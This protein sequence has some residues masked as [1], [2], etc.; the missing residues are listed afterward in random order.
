[1][2]ERGIFGVPRVPEGMLGRK[3]LVGRVGQSP[4]TVIRAP[5]GGGK[6][7]LM[8]QWAAQKSASGVWVTV[9]PDIG[10][11]VSFWNAVVDAAHVVD[12]D[13][14]THLADVP[15]R[16]ALRGD[17]LRAF[18]AAP[19]PFVLVVDDAHELIDRATFE[20]ILAV[21]HACP[22]V[23]AVVGTRARDELES[24]RHALTLDIEVIGPDEL[25]LRAADVAAIAGEHGSR[26]GTTTELLEASGGNPLLLR[27]ILAGSLAGIGGQ[28]S[29][30]AVVLDY[31][32]G[33]FATDG[34]GF[35]AFAAATA[36]PD[37][38]DVQLAA[39]LSGL[40]TDRAESQ[41]TSLETDGLVM[42]RDSADGVR[43]RYHPLIREVLRGEMRRS[44]PDGFR[45]TS[46]RAS[47]SAESRRHFLPAL[48]H[49]VDAEDY[50]RA[51]DV[52]LHGGFTLMRSRGSAAIVQ[53]VPLRYIARLPF[54]AV[55]L[56]L[57]ANARGDRWKALQ[58]LTLALGASRAVRHRQRVSER[59]G[60]ALI[61]TVILRI[62]GRAADSVAQAR[63]MLAL[64]D[65]AQPIEL[66]E[67]A[68]QVGSYRL[69]AAMSLFRAGCLSEA[70]AAAE[71][72]GVSEHSLAE[73]KSESLGA[74]A[75]VAA[76]EAVLGEC[77]AATITLAR[78]DE[79]DY[80]VDL[81][82]GY[83]GSLAHL[84][85][86]IVA[87]ESADA[88]GAFRALELFVGREN[89]EHGL[90]FS[91]ARGFVELWRGAP[92]VGLRQL[93]ERE[94]TDRTKA[95]VSP[96]DRIIL[97][98]VR[99]LLHA[100]LG[101]MGSAHEVL[102]GMDR[103]APVAVILRAHISLLEQRP[104]LVVE[105]LS[106]QRLPQAPRLQ[107]AS[108]LLM[109]CASLL[110]N[111]ESV[112]ETALRR[113]FAI[114]HVHGTVSPVIL[115]PAEYRSMLYE[116]AERTGAKGETLARLRSMPEPFHTTLTLPALTPREADVLELLRKTGSL[117]EVAATLHVSANTV[118]SQVRTLYRK[119]GVSHRDEAL[120]AA[121]LQGLLRE[122]PL[123]PA[124]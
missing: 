40:T 26:Y 27:A 38:V 37:D 63:R 75:L 97:A 44:D 112:A 111:D 21:I 23:T 86:G 118:K 4:L 81:R 92:D 101:Q 17:L 110:R 96:E 72:V 12:I 14:G 99:V 53:Q 57:A 117:P 123:R 124:D 54:L 46:L 68:D 19:D 104:D 16:E 66:E 56:G 60:F 48:R 77:S 114:L 35:A 20:D 93:S 116:F 65:E 39:H 69:Q 84:A 70:K 105:H 90:L 120:R 98:V 85:Q 103:S 24:P 109:A 36:I 42:R 41:L 51:S 71:R 79:S 28:T 1:M 59:I 107:A 88:D 115:V 9:E 49:A 100:A 2:S 18:R 22:N 119:L 52:C 7:V 29:P 108:E 62:T 89:L 82:D 34:A 6:T 5:G 64:L 61:E 43:F 50:S 11:Q 95:R 31:L 45:S 83:V 13:L 106:G 8:A 80:P 73:G 3:S 33:L 121:Y 78:I 113:F 55:V 15:N 47:A 25:V 67:I 32:R 94:L 87:L 102:R 10:T 76:I 30:Q 91:V 74:T 58:M 122:D